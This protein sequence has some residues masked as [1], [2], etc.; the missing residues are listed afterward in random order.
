MICANNYSLKTSGR[1]RDLWLAFH[2]PTKFR[3]SSRVPLHSWWPFSSPS[4]HLPGSLR[5]QVSRRSTTPTVQGRWWWRASWIPCR[6]V[7]WS[8]W[9]WWTSLLLISSARGWAA[10]Q[11]CNLVPTLRC[12]LVPWPW[13]LLP[14]GLSQ[15]DGSEANAWEDLLNWIPK[16][17][18]LSSC[19]L[20]VI[21]GE[22]RGQFSSFSFSFLFQYSFVCSLHDGGGHTSQS[23]FWSC[24]TKSLFGMDCHG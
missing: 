23:L 20:V 13:H 14:S 12:S 5:G 22:N 10:T 8:T 3:L 2:C 18:V 7:Y 24:K 17:Q 15:P 21:L 9:P 1:A 11:G 16:Q 6:P 19:L 4:Q